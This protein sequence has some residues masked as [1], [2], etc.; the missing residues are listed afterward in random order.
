MVLEL[1]MERMKDMTVP[2]DP[3][4]QQGHED[5]CF[6]HTAWLKPIQDWF[7][8]NYAPNE[9]VSCH[10]LIVSNDNSNFDMGADSDYLSSVNWYDFQWTNFFPWSAEDRLHEWE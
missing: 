9:P 5:A 2:A 10:N 3:R 8:R 4:Q 1:T 6:S 7:N